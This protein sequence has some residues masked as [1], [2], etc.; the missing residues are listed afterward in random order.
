MK[1]RI[2]IIG[3]GIVGKGVGHVFSHFAEDLTIYDKYQDRSTLEETVSQ[4][5]IIFIAVP[6]PCDFEAMSIDLSIMDEVVARIATLDTEGKTFVIKS[7]VVPGTTARYE[8]QFPHLRLSMV[9][10]F[11]RED[12]FLQDAEDPERVVI[13]ANKPEVRDHIVQ[14]YQWR[15]PR[16][17]HYCTSSTEA[18]LVK[19]MSNCYLAV[20]VI[21]ANIFKELADATGA[22]YA[23]AKTALTADPRIPDDHLDVTAE[24]GFGGKCFPKD[25]TA[26]IGVGRKLGVDVKLLE[27]AWDWNLSHRSVRDWEAIPGAATGGAAHGD[28][29]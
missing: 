7:T 21:F 19:Y 27:E 20:K 4:S 3:Y 18:E 13:G 16:T 11:L 22:D 2:G 8:E 23:A 9:P 14:L 5:E 24:R 25:L 10:E 17:P 15:F 28:H 26:M 6:T 12:T 29:L 1:A